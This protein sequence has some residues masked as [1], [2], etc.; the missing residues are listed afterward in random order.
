MGGILDRRFGENDPTM[1]PEER[2]AERYARESLKQSKKASMFNLEDDE[3]EMQ[4]TH[5]G[6]SLS[7]GD[8][9]ENDD[10]N[11]D[12]V[13]GSDEEDHSSDDEHR[14]RKRRRI[15]DPDEVN[16]VDEGGHID[17]PARQK[18]RNEVMKEV[19]AKSKLHKYER[20]KTKEDDD[21][22]RAELDKGLPDLYELVRGSKLPSAQAPAETKDSSTLIN[23]DRAALL[24]GKD[25][26]EAD[27]EYDERLRQMAFDKRS[28]PAER[29]KTEE[30]KL[31][32][33]AERLKVLERK[34][35]RRMQG[36]QE[37]SSDEDE[38]DDVYKDD[39]KSLQ[40]DA[41]AFGLN[42]TVNDFT[43]GDDL[44]VEDEDDFVI[45]EDLV[46]SESDIELS[47]IE[48]SS[49]ESDDWDDLLEEDHEFTAGLSL[50]VNGE[51]HMLKSSNGSTSKIPTDDGLA[52]TFPCPQTHEEFLQAIEGTRIE[53][54]PIIV[55]RIRALYNSKLQSE[56]KPKLERFSAVL[57]E[58]VAFLAN[59]PSHPP[60]SVLESLLRHIHS[61]A[62]GHPESVG[63]AFRVHL[64]DL[65]EN[66]PLK[67]LPGDIIVLTG[68]S[69]IF[70]TSDHFHQVVTPAILTMARYLGQSSI[71]SLAD[72]AIG[73]YVSSLCIQYQNLSKRYVPELMNYV[74]NALCIL[75]PVESG[76]DLDY[77][78]SR[79]PPSPLRLSSLYKGEV[80]RMRL[81]DFSPR[82]DSDVGGEE[83]KVALMETFVTLLDIAA[84][85]WTA[86][87]AFYEIFDASRNV[88]QHLLG[89][90]CA[91]KLP[92]STQDK[93]RNTLEKVQRLLGK[94][95][96]ERRPL[97]LHNHRPLA[98]KT[99][100]PRFEESF[101]PDRHYDPHRERSGLSKL[102]AEHKRE[103]KGALREL[104]KD[105]NFIARESL[106]EKKEKDAA[107]EKKFKRLVAEI[108]GEEGKEAKAYER[109]KR[110]RKGKR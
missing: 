76:H 86:K 73:A 97:L 70:P 82:E 90:S 104:R 81:W 10:F 105:A 58:H 96:L 99:A 110:I 72:L 80:R 60:F 24:N 106:R 94:S 22:L 56:N 3:E 85:L 14:S 18:T 27:K 5:L 92:K 69:T 52:F 61:L 75:A 101:N 17:T 71:K 51:N 59:Q 47:A 107:Y 66:R 20:Q 45:D 6:R 31:E 55:Q 42:Q 39:E 95:R 78:P 77:F 83:L 109:E 35:L 15:L 68:V 40:D 29:T 19:I 13:R 62:K 64:R 32:E 30:E 98:I 21:D 44:A 87:S 26:K 9:E 2:A 102:K 63:G 74:L 12:D 38:N 46:A 7:F 4:L 84:D 16:G 79:H 50:P 88:L 100:I 25:R 67:P 41:E 108:Q 36:V 89:K 34:R 8:S 54:L 28:Q 65:S 48:S 43:N 57:V 91:S 93:V 11:E 23:P 33:Q 49:N 53:Q 1:T 103:R 37:D